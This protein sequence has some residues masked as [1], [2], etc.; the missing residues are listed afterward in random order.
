[1]QDNRKKFKASPKRFHPRGLKILYE[2][3]DILVVFKSSGLL[4]MSTDRIRDK[5]AYF[6]LNNYVRKGVE[7]SRNRVFI[8]HRLDRDTSGVLVFAKSE[9]VKIFLQAEWKGFSK[10]YYAVVH[11]ILSKKEDVISSYLT[12]NIAHKVYSVQDPA[13]GKL[14][15]TGY[16]VLKEGKNY[17]LLEIDLKT[18]RKNQIRAQF[19]EMGHPVAGDKVYG[20]ND[21]ENRK[22]ALHAGVLTLL[23]PVSKEKMVFEAP[24]PGYFKS[25][26]N[27]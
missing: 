4:T 9:K 2:D 10:K 27:S 15:Q 3:H 26:L 13:K 8:V 6:L 20:N 12:E 17:S 14:A 5:T 21:K 22:L 1:M 18:G 19:S 23:H 25:L 11:G 24:T 7:K 16:K